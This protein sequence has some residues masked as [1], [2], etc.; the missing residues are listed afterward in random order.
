MNQYDFDP[1][2]SSY[3]FSAQ[4]VGACILIGAM[5]ILVQIFF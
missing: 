1:N 3:V 2:N 4:V 5:L